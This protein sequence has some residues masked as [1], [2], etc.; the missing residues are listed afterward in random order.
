MCKRTKLVL[1][2]VG[3]FRLYGE[4][5]VSACVEAGTDYLDITG[6]P[7]FMERMELRYHE[8]A[9]EKGCLIVSACGYDSIPAEI[10]LIHHLKHW[11]APC[12]PNS[13]DCFLQIISSKKFVGNTGTWESA[14]LG[15]SSASDLRK[16]RAQ[17][18]K[19]RARITVP[20][21]PAKKPALIHWNKHLSL[22]SVFLPSAD[23]SVVRRTMSTAASGAPPSIA[24]EEDPNLAP[25]AYARKLIYMPVHFGVY[26]GLPNIFSVLCQMWMGLWV[27]CLAMFAFGRKLLLRFPEFFSAGLFQKGGPNEEQV[28]AARFTMWFVGKG[29]SDSTMATASR[30]VQP[31]LQI[32]TAVSGPEIGYITTPICLVQCA[33][34]VL[35]D[36]RS[37]PRGGVYTPGTVFGTTD[38][39]QRL[40]QNGISFD[41]LSRKSI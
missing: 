12:L 39:Q 28:A 30:A 37:L 15:V 38:L 20:G 23:S 35:S 2:C 4:P 11:I 25:V 36:R 34:I 21:A 13:V 41:F 6:E 29:Y 9:R 33:L 31:D 1:N 8:A 14:V 24:E 18:R 19:S 16:L 32:T 17:S 26:S 7:E 10:G 22:W 27:M 40:E 5:V 3:P